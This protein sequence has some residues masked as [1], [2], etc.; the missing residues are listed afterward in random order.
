MACC[1][2]L[3]ADRNS[4]VFMCEIQLNSRTHAALMVSHCCL[5]L[6]SNERLPRPS[7]AASAELRARMPCS[8]PSRPGVVALARSG[9]CMHA[10]R[11]AA[12]RDPRKPRAY[13]LSPLGT[14]YLIYSST[15][16][17]VRHGWRRALTG[18]PRAAHWHWSRPRSSSQAIIPTSYSQTRT[19]W[20]DGWG[21]SNAKARY[22]LFPRNGREWVRPR[23]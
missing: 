4:V 2:R 1:G 16:A 3:H 6:Q 5:W 23:F 9:A 8:A 20:I 15:P 7:A 21:A 13:L 10:R 11:V 14:G 17:S 19:C 12:A 18:W 22:V